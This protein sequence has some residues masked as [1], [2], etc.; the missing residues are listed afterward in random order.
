[1]PGL[2]G[3]VKLTIFLLMLHKDGSPEICRQSFRFLFSVSELF[4]GRKGVRGVVDEEV[5][6]DDSFAFFGTQ[7]NAEAASLL[8]E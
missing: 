2:L 5:S 8:W 4:V 3:L 7:A 1:V 6:D